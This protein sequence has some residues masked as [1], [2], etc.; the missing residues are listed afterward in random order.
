MAHLRLAPKEN[1]SSFRR[2]AIGTWKTTG[3]PS[4]YGQLAMR[5]DKMMAYIDEL[6][7]RSGRHVTLSHVM[8]KCV[9]MVLSEMPD[10]NAMLRFNRIYLRED[11][12][13]FFQVALEDPKTKEVDL[14][15]A[16]IFDCHK[17]S[18]IEIV[19]EFEA[20]VGLV[21]SL[22]DKSL[23][24]T[25]STFKSI[26]FFM[27]NWVLDTIS[28]LTYTLN[29]D[30]SGLGLPKDPFGSVMITNIGSLGLEEG[31]VPLVPYSKLPLLIA[32]GALKDEVIAEDGKMVI[33][34][35][36][37][38]CATFDHRVLDG[39]HAAKMAK[40]LHRIFA[41]PEGELGALPEMTA[42]LPAKA[43]AE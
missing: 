12:G 42:A 11:I 31:Y 40:T 25:R 20:K 30:L 19:D 32:L 29:L 21:R 39:M 22:K 9:S 4:V 43:A 34:K 5:S 41:N 1:L 37:K 15:G 23:E 7:R 28:F 38:L 17:K 8:A 3:D 6:R 35:M 13:V 10:A 24:K 16:T 26:P 2:I 14:S 36:L 18:V 27:L 33:A